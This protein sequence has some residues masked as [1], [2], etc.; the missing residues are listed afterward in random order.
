M[1]CWPLPPASGCLAF[2]WL[3]SWKDGV[4]TPDAPR[5]VTAGQGR[6]W[7]DFT[8]RRP[9][10]LDG[11][12]TTARNRSH[13]SRLHGPTHTKS[14]GCAVHSDDAEREKAL[15]HGVVGGCV[16]W[17]DGWEEGGGLIAVYCRRTMGCDSCLVYQ[18]QVWPIFAAW[19]PAVAYRDG[20]RIQVHGMWISGEGPAT[21]MTVTDRTTETSGHGEWGGERRYT[22]W[23]GAKTSSNTIVLL[24][25][26]C[27]LPN[28][29]RQ[30]NT[31]LHNY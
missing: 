23:R 8:R 29:P 30:R 20:L 7:A 13:G 31:H 1:A 3:W 25:W 6:S 12:K 16:R 9:D 26:Q 5:A 19:L 22:V 24:S 10:P 17:C 27:T 2:P 18:Q 4:R 21:V 28:T 11:R 14:P 15:W